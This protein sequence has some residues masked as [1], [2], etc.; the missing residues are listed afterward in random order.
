MGIEDLLREALSEEARAASEQMADIEFED[1]VQ[2]RL[3]EDLRYGGLY[4]LMS[5]LGMQGQGDQE[6]SIGRRAVIKSMGMPSRRQ[7]QQMAT[8]LGQ[9]TPPGTDE[10]AIARDV[11][12]TLG[13][14]FYQGSYPKPDEIRYFQSTDREL[15][16]E[17]GKLYR[18]EEYEGYGGYGGLDDLSKTINH[19][20]F[21]RA[22]SLP[23]FQDRLKEL[24]LEMESI[25]RDSVRG[26]LEYMRLDKEHAV[27][28]DFLKHHHYYLNAIDADYPNNP[29]ERKLK[30]SFE[31]ERLPLTKRGLEQLQ[32]DTRRYLTP[33]KQ[34][35]LGVRLP[36]PAVKPKEPPSFVERALDYA[37]DIF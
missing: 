8:I 27:L 37:K 23:F 19:E 18:G 35:E 20:L 25:D 1:E 13:L 24:E 9:Y 30:E 15:R 22:Q 28:H 17:G 6:G 7:Q 21:H 2:T 12:R 31:G 26:Q 10:D 5:Y 14:D 3:P 34:K 33:E 16:D 11:R 29:G 36:I 4:G 32:E